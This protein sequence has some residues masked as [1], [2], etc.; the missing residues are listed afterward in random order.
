[1]TVVS[2]RYYGKLRELIGAK[3]EEYL[4]NKEATIA[5][6]LMKLIPEKHFEVS[7]TWIETLFRTIKKEV[8]QNKN[9]TPALKNYMILVN[10]K[11]AKLDD[12]LKDGD[13]ITIMPPFGGG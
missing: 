9:G 6:L 8:M 12:L 1:M 5:D 2:V 10:G 13:E 11:T 7:Q 4:V 3:T